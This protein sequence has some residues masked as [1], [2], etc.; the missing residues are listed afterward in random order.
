MS[1]EKK[2]DTDIL[3]LILCNVAMILCTLLAI[4]NGNDR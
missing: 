2:K 1:D 3:P 4:P